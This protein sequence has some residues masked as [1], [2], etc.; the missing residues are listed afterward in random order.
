MRWW[1]EGWSSMPHTLLSFFSGDCILSLLSPSLGLHV[2]GVLG[3]A[4]GWLSLEGW[5]RA[6]GTVQPGGHLARQEGRRSGLEWPLF[7]GPA[8]PC[9]GVMCSLLWGWGSHLGCLPGLRPRP[10]P[11]WPCSGG[12]HWSLRVQRQCLGDPRSPWLCPLLWVTQRGPGFLPLG[13][14]PQAGAEQKLHQPSQV[15]PGAPAS[16][17]WGGCGAPPCL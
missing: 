13:P 12:L 3:Q 14:R 8:D 2:Q 17:V 1:E 4:Q 10:I 11:G 15:L 6:L 5:A 7:P 9:S 16:V